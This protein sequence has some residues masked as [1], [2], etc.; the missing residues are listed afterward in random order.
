MYWYMLLWVGFWDN[1]LM[2]HLE[3][4]LTDL[5]QNIME[6]AAARLDLMGS[7]RVE[8]DMVKLEVFTIE[9]YMLRIYLVCSH[10]YGNWI[11]LTSK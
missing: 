4:G 10:A 9:Y 8:T 5:S 6:S 7:S 11:H 3:H 1:I 2:R